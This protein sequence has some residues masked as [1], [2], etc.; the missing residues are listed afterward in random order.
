MQ[1]FIVILALI[2]LAVGL[3]MFFIYKDKGEREPIGALWMAFG[4]GIFAAL[5]ASVIENIVIPKDIDSLTFTKIILVASLSIGIIEEAVKFVPVAI[6]IYRKRFF[7]EHTDGIVYF[8]LA[9][10]GFGLLENINYAMNYG[11]STGIRRLLLTPFFHAAITCLVGFAL[12]IVK[13][14]KKSKLWVVGALVMAMLI[15]GI[16][17]FGIFS[18]ESIFV[19]LSIIITLSL[20]AMLFWLYFRAANMD[21]NLGLSSVGHIN[22]CRNC[23]NPNKAHHLYCTHCGQRV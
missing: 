21:Q 10:L 12:I 19:V 4:L 11:A 20:S 16:Y 2:I 15:H 6:Y 7:N 5:I 18:G 22:Y 3:A 1:L 14:D 23:G 13:L 8:A 9:G 17:D